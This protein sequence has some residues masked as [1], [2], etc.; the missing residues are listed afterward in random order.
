MDGYIKSVAA[1]SFECLETG[2]RIRVVGK[3]K[4]DVGTGCHTYTSHHRTVN[5]ECV[6]AHRISLWPV[7][8]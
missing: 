6:A 3:G 2:A 7:T 5:S 4:E 1:V 8:L